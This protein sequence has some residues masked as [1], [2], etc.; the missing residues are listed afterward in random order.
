[1]NDSS[2]PPRSSPVRPLWIPEGV[3]LD[4]LPATL[5]RG[6]VEIINLVY[7]ER[8]MGAN[9]ALETAQGLSYVEL[10]WW[11]L[12]DQVDLTADWASSLPYG[13][14]S[15]GSRAKF[16]RLMRTIAL[17]DKIANFLLTA[18]RFYDKAGSTD[19]LHRVPR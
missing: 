17:K 4:Q 7:E 8:V 3:N 2:T 12:L 15:K 5:Q 18:E 11:E 14:S 1:M 13:R 6:I 19:P 16:S 9:T 10:A